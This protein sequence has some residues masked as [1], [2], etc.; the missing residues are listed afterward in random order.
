MW[1]ALGLEGF[2]YERGLLFSTPSNK[3]PW[4]DFRQQTRVKYQEYWQMLMD[5]K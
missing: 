4:V 5:I 2:G 1:L 3:L